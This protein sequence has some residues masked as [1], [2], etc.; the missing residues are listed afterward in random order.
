MAVKLKVK[1]KPETEEQPPKKVMLKVRSNPTKDEVKEVKQFYNQYLNSPNYK[2][3]LLAQGYDDPNKTI[4]ERLGTLNSVGFT[5]TPNIGSK[6]IRSKG[7]VNFDANENR[8]YGVNPINVAAHELSHTAGGI[9]F[10]GMTLK[11]NE[12][13]NPKEI[14]LIDQ[15][16]KSKDLHDSMAG[17]VKADID[18]LRFQLKKKGVYD[19]GTQTFDKNH[20][21]KARELFSTD[22]TIKRVFDRFKDE[23][24]IKIMNSIADNNIKPNNQNLV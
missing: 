9:G 18:A 14:Q 1:T 6:F 21:R 4:A 20:L 11:G 15:G 16:N 2:A 24:I 10:T 19:T 8:K 5:E 3:R 17:E 12:Y 7:V 23:D 13:L 22:P